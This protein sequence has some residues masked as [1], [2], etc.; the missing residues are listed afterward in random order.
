MPTAFTA[1]SNRRL[2]ATCF[3]VGGA[4]SGAA[5]ASLSAGAASQRIVTGGASCA[6]SQSA[7]SVSPASNW[8]A[9]TSP[10]AL[11]QPSGDSARLTVTVRAALALASADRRP[12]RGSGRSASILF[13][14]CSS[15]LRSAPCH[16][17]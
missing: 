3:S 1:A 12:S 4:G 10:R 13:F 14:I 2:A 7:R 8:R 5:R 16:L 6:R 17:G 9:L 15:E 11:S